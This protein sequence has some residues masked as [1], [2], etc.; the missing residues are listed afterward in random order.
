VGWYGSKRAD[1]AT[2]SIGGNDVWFADFVINC[3]ITIN[4]IESAEE[5]RKACIDIGLKADAYLDK[6]IGDQ[7]GLLFKLKTQY[8][9]IMRF[10]GRDV[11]II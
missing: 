1:L 4:P 6:G 10:A 11:R 5:Y 2:L 3:V 7:T 9:K 8:N